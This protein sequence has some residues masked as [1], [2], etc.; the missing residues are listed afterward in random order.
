MR[1]PSA[2]LILEGVH[3][4]RH[5]LERL[6]EHHQTVGVRGALA[7]LDRSTD[8]DP[9]LAAVFLGRSLAGVCDQYFMSADRRG[10]LVVAAGAEGGNFPWVLVTY[11]R[12]GPRQQ[13]VAEQLL[14]AA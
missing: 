12:F 1:R 6:R 3:V 7:L 11:L 4:S 14:G 9:E 13:A 10:I 5:A 8:I 2:A